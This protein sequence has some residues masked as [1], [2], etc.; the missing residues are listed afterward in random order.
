MIKRVTNPG[1]DDE[2]EE[3][4]EE[5]WEWEKFIVYLTIKLI[6]KFNAKSK[7]FSVGDEAKFK[8]KLTCFLFGG[9]RSCY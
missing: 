7:L 9:E 5:E 6:P 2:E 1:Y 8:S 4:E 3:E